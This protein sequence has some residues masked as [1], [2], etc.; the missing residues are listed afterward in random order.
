MPEITKEK[1]IERKQYK[2]DKIFTKDAY[3]YT[4]KLKNGIKINDTL[5]A[6]GK[7]AEAEIF[8]FIQNTIS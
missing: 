2:G 7:E 6:Y 8:R 1:T 3:F 5:Y 4:I